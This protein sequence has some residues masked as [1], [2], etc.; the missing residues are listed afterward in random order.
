MV[1]GFMRRMAQC[2]E[3]FYAWITLPDHRDL[4]KAPPNEASS[5]RKT[6]SA[7]FYGTLALPYIGF[8]V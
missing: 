8:Y 7:P 3:G 4:W 1:K 5:S 2:G 6:Q